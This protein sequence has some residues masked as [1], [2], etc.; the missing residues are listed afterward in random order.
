MAINEH[1]YG[2]EDTPSS[3][4]FAHAQPTMAITQAIHADTLTLLL[5]VSVVEWWH[6]IQT[7]THLRNLP[8]STVPGVTFTAAIYVYIHLPY[9]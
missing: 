1:A 4:Q 7:Y 8:N 2:H 9:R 5:L 3:S 6:N